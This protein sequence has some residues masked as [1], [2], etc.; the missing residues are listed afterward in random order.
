VRKG[1]CSK[2]KRENIMCKLRLFFVGSD[3]KMNS[4]EMVMSF[5]EDIKAMIDHW[6]IGGRM[7]IHEFIEV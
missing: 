3:G 1:S 5:D 6:S 4:S 2:P 7:V